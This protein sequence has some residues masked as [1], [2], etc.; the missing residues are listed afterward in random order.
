MA[1]TLIFVFFLIYV[2]QA[3]QEKAINKKLFQNRSKEEADRL[4]QELAQQQEIFKQAAQSGQKIL[5]QPQTQ[6]KQQVAQP[7]PQRIIPQPRTILS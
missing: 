7:A 5:P 4:K 2:Y 3:D 6:L 1:P